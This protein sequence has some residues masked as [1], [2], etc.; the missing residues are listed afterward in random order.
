M[1]ANK[2]QILSS[3]PE[4][5]LTLSGSALSA[6]GLGIKEG[7]NRKPMKEVTRQEWAEE[8]LLLREDRE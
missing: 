5:D 7:Q 8:G 2:Q 1:K 6:R 4:F 3:R